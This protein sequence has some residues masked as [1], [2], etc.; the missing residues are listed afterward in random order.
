VPAIVRVSCATCDFAQEA[1]IPLTLV[2]DEHGTE[3]V[4]GHPGERRD[5]ERITG[6]SWRELTR[7]NR[8]RHRHALICMTCGEVR[9]Y[10]IPP[11]RRRLGLIA[12]ITVQP[13]QRDADGIACQSCR[14]T[15]LSPLTASFAGTLCPAC[16]QATLSS[17]VVAIA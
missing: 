16:K 11:R 1:H 14:A 7:Q 10:A 12:A 15:T 17:A 5:A 9:H 3:H 8:I 2:V 6:L 13:K 4:C